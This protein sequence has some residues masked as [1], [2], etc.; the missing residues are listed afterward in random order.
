MENNRALI[1]NLKNIQTP[2]YI[3]NQSLLTKNLKLLKKIKIQSGAK[4]LLA[5]KGFAFSPFMPLVMKYLDGVCASGLHEAMYAN[6][7]DAKQIHTFSVAFKHDEFEQI[8]NI[9]DFIVFNSFSQY[10]SFKNK[11]KNTNSLGLRINPE[12]SSVSTNIYDPCSTYSRL[13]I[14][15]ENFHKELL[16]NQN[17]LSD[18]DGFHFHALFEQNA[19]DL[20]KVLEKFEENFSVYF[21]QL[22]WINFGGGHHITRDD[23][24]VNLLIK[25]IKEF[26]QKYPN[27]EVILEPGEAIGWKTGFLLTSVLDIVHNE[28]NIAVLDTSAEAH[29][30]DTLIMPYKADVR[31]ASK[32]INKYNFVYKLAGNTCLAGDIMGDYSF[33][34]K[35]EIGDKIIF[36]DMIH[37][38][39]VKNTT[40]N[41]IKLPNLAII[42]ENKNIVVKKT[43]SYDDYKNRN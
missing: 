18:I 34:E 17:I 12:V 42:D 26:K 4:I 25:I 19:L 7:Y 20:K 6:D 1:Q 14:T 30:P 37:Y 31:D 3:C 15:K 43:F 5:L 2:C 41:G 27:I 10:K 23:Y 33:K 9:S 28:M 36:E 22:K 32:D 29:M 35:L 13:G 8:V 16:I 39:I 38:T 40:F 21:S 24:D 11:T